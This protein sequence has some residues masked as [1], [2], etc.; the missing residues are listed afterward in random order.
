MPPKDLTKANR[1]TNYEIQLEGELAKLVNLIDVFKIKLTSARN[2]MGKEKVRIKLSE[3]ECIKIVEDMQELKNTLEDVIFRLN[4][5]VKVLQN[6]TRNEIF[7]MKNSV[8]FAERQLADAK[9]LIKK[10][11]KEITKLTETLDL[12][13]KEH[14]VA[15]Q[16]IWITSNNVIQESFDKMKERCFIDLDI[17][18]K[19]ATTTHSDLTKAYKPAGEYLLFNII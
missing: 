11:N 8:A 4:I 12:E 2:L 16:K 14:T 3:S 15:I 10:Q 7:R 9:S 17:W 19:N 5:F 1:K 6:H 13:R 18:N